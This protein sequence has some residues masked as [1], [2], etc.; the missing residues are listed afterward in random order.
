[1][2]RR[3][4]PAGHA[5]VD[6]VPARLLAGRGVGDLVAA[7]EL[8]ERVAE[9]A[10]EAG[11]RLAGADASAGLRSQIGEEPLVGRERVTQAAGVD[12]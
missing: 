9:R 2:D 3:A 1:M 4:A 11:P 8:L 7:A 5:H 10:G 6:G 12:P